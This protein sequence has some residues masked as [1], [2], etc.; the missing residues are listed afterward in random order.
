ME[1]FVCIG[2]YC[3]VLCVYAN[4]HHQIVWNGARI[5]IHFY[6]ALS[7][8]LM[9]V[10]TKNNRCVRCFTEIFLCVRPLL[11]ALSYCTSD[12]V[13]AP[14][15]LMLV[16]QQ[17]HSRQFIPNE[18][19]ATTFTYSP[20][21]KNGFISSSATWYCTHCFFSG[22]AAL[23]LPIHKRYI[24]KLDALP[25]L[26]PL[27]QLLECLLI[28]A[29]RCW[30]RWGVLLQVFSVLVLTSCFCVADLKCGV[31]IKL[32]NVCFVMHYLQ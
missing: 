14:T 2:Q 18:V 11:Y 12:R 27:L 6:N 3:C 26:F 24:R 31:I 8:W 21:E 1:L 29:V 20:T 7:S 23:H 5:C 19:S 32:V 4:Y 16:I 17:N 10:G 15:P 30:G 28:V 25:I 13:A 22:F 9:K